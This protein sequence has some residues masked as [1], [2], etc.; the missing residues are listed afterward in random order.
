VAKNPVD[1]FAGC[2]DYRKATNDLDCHEERHKSQFPHVF[3]NLRKCPPLDRRPAN[4]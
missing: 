4:R 2:A 3:W 1:N